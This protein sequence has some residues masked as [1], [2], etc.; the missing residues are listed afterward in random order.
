MKELEKGRMGPRW[1]DVPLVW[2]SA[3]GCCWRA[4]ADRTAHGLLLLLARAAARWRLAPS[5]HP[6]EAFSLVPPAAPP[7]GRCAPGPKPSRERRMWAA[8]S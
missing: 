6:E 2:P 5:P 3:S 4:G 8:I 7:P 1:W